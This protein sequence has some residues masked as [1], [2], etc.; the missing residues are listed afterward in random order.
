MKA[1]KML[2][3]LMIAVAIGLF[4]QPG[5]C[6]AGDEDEVK[7]VVKE[8]LESELFELD[9]SKSDV[10]VTAYYFHGR[11][12]CRSCR[13]IE[14]YAHDALM[15]Y[16]PKEIESG[17]IEW[18]VENYL[19]PQNKRFKKT[20]ELFAASVVFVE[21]KSEEIERWTNLKDV[22]TI[23]KDQE[24]FYEYIKTEMHAFISEGK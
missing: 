18:K 10:N 23:K 21:F 11:K 5:V 6:V 12:R 13:T 16:F 17:Q 9:S 1:L 14:L 15:K 22:W 19:N 4:F 7:P 3:I 24:K 2:Y 20:F 8:G